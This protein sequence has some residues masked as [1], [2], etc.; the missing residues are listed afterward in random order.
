M[1]VETA[2]ALAMNRNALAQ[3][4]NGL[5]ERMLKSSLCDGKVFTCA[6]EQ[7][8]REKW[9]VYVEKQSS[10]T[11]GKEGKHADTKAVPAGEGGP[12]SKSTSLR[13]ATPSGPSHY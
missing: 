3:I 13:V 10:A 11:N 12:P 9:Q 5:R 8:Y 1:Y 6:L 7:I 4:R 2:V